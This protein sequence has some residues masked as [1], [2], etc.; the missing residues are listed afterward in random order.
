MNKP[1]GGNYGASKALENGNTTAITKQ[2]VG[3][4]WKASFKGSFM[5]YGVK[6][7]NRFDCCGERLASTMVT[8]GGQECG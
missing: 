2:G 3:N 4:W 8:I 7:M 1:Y 6:V 5:V